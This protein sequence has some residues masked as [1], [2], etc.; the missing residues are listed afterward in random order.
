MFWEAGMF[1][2]LVLV[3]TGILLLVVTPAVYKGEEKNGGVIAYP[4]V[5]L[6]LLVAGLWGL[7]SIGASTGNLAKTG[8]LEQNEIY[9]TIVRTENKGECL[10]ILR[11]REEGLLAISLAAPCPPH[12]FVWKDRRAVS[13]PA[14]ATLT[15]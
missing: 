14:S 9:E 12:L 4:G 2:S 5:G 8:V 1:G 3:C 15:K 6:V 13:Y 7:Y 10:A 11:T